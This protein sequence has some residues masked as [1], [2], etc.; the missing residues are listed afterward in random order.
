[1]IK[2]NEP[3]QTTSVESKRIRAV[4]K[5]VGCLCRAVSYVVM[6]VGDPAGQGLVHAMLNGALCDVYA[7]GYT[8]YLFMPQ[9]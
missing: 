2:P 5:L 4:H 6:Q 7:M 1:M 9:F 8:W 3:V